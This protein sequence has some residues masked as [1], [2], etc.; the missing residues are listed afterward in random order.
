[1]AAKPGW[2]SREAPERHSLD[3]VPLVIF[4]NGI[5]GNGSINVWSTLTTSSMALPRSG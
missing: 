4:Y 3:I 5:F 2:N 1:M